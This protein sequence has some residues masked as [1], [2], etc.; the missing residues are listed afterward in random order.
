MI[1]LKHLTVERFR[2][3]REVNL[4]FPQRGS[5]L[6]QGPNESGKSALIESIYFA[7]YGEPLIAGRRKR[8]LD[9]LISY[10]ATHATITLILSIGTT[11]MTV[12][13]TIERNK[14]QYVTLTI[15][16]LGMPPE[17]PITDIQT[18]NKCIIAELGH[19]DSESLRNSCLLEQ[20]GL[21]RLEILNGTGREATIRKLL[22]VDRLMELTEQ[23]KVVQEDEQELQEGHERLR[24]AEIQMRIPELSQR[25]DDIETALDAVAVSEDLQEID[26]Q[27]A[28]IAE[29]EQVQEQIQHRRNELKGQ[30]SRIQ[31]LR[32]ADETLEKIITC[33]E[34]IADARLHVPELEKQIADMELRERED[35][36]ALEKR[37]NELGELTRSF[38]TLQRMSNDLLAAV[39]TIKELEQEQ[40]QQNEVRKDLKSLDEQV[41]HA[42]M[43][44]EQAQQALQEME[45][46]RRSGRPQLE[47]RLQRMR[48]LSERLTVLRQ[49]EDR[50]TRRMG[51]LEQAEESEAQLK[52]VQND[53]QNTEETLAQLEDEA[54]QAQSQ[55]DAIDKRWRQLNIGHH[56]EDWCRLKGLSQ[57]LND[58]EQ[59]V[60]LAHQHQEK[61]MAALHT[62][63]SNTFKYLGILVVSV[64]VFLV[65]VVASFLFLKAS[66]PLA[67]VLG[68][69]AIVAVVAAGW[70]WLR[71]PKEH[72]EKTL[73]EQQVQEAINKVS[74]A[75]ASREAAA[76]MMGNNEALSQVEYQ[77]RNL[78]GN[79]PRSIEEAQDLMR[80]MRKESESPA[81]VQQQLK[82]K[83]DAANAARDQV[84]A[85]M[86]TADRL[87]QE[88]ASIEAQRVQEGWDNIDLYLQEDQAAVD[89][90]QQEITL[91]AGQEGLPLPSINARLQQTSSF[92]PFPS[93]ALQ[94]EEEA[95]GIP[96]LES[97]VEST[98]KATERELASLDGKLDLVTDL[99]AQVKIH[100]D[101]VDVLLS[102]KKAVEERIALYE[103]NNVALQIERAREQQADLRQA[104]QTLQD[105]LRQRVKPLGVAFGQ[106]AI[107]NA[108]ATA[109]RQLEE[110]QITLG[111]KMMLQEKHA[112]YTNRL[113]ERQESLAEHYKQ[114]ARY[115]NSLGSWIVPPNP[116]AE[117]LVALRTRCQNEIQEADEASIL[118]EFEEL[119]QREGASRAKVELCYQEISEIQDRIA[120]MLTQRNR[121]KPKSYSLADIAT[122]WPL[123]NQ[124]SVQNRPQLENDRMAIEQE[125]DRLEEQELAL[126]AQLQTGGETLDGE[127]ER[128]HVEQL[129]RTYQV[130]K[131]GNELIKAVDQRLMRK[132]LPRT[133]YYMQQILPLLTSGR[134]HDVHLTT[135]SEEGVIS[136]G[137]FELSVWD[138]AAGEYVARS[139][140]SGGAADQLSLALRLAFAIATLPHELNLA[141]GFIV[142]DEPL[143]SF[144]RGRAQ[145]LVDVVTGDILSQHFEQILLISHSNAF[146]PS[147]FPYHVYMDNGLVVESNLPVV[148]N[149][150]PTTASST[151]DTSPQPVIT[152]IAPS[153]TP[154]QIGVE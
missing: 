66:L 60:R 22:G 150:P 120:T 30:Q 86:E 115:S 117:V 33:Y 139:A 8:S 50:Y 13:R 68:V 145:A 45:E 87:R 99:A 90:M 71:Y 57:G 116:F 124:Y 61:L 55:A 147:M 62:A 112:D 151:G 7:L 144:D 44:L 137:P 130:K 94:Q 54:A 83:V 72:A 104:L 85:A 31:Q 52:K 78:G 64:L 128:V 121:P 108:E 67:I 135:A 28:D 17:E 96:E 106:T 118:H 27:N 32:N 53:F 142:L 6:I 73:A 107:T 80:Q 58:A 25:L 59:Q 9:D 148:P 18:A 149:F 29:Q 43:R 75:V 93:I 110:M 141:P 92:S 20:K 132:M 81:D 23:F 127:R 15:R 56:L 74:S 82:E 42:K 103:K 100:Q 41:A 16:R 26:L 4:H 146:D 113:K 133:E 12:T 126:S 76:R 136:G 11:E 65:C 122:V 1:I 79:I 89:R 102:R 125:L 5:I 69:V 48:T 91:L 19:V 111:N 39:D 119:Q 3:L 114:L 63:R 84:N 70:S 77:I 129:E 2:L 88:V 34:E 98:I 14:G 153:E 97:L 109:R 46:R 10:G 49:V 154:E 152:I 143:S 38:G 40:K 123:L 36:P 37:V 105:S 131:R 35:L 134:Y 21:E 95:I 138:S 51:S 140:L 101:A 47:A 24:L